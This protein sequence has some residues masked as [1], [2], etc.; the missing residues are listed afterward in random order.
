MINP[1]YDEDRVQ[2][3]LTGLVDAIAHPFDAI[4]AD[5]FDRTQGPLNDDLTMVMLTR[6]PGDK[7]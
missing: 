4:L 6:P 1:I 7:A 5:F 3:A 2:A